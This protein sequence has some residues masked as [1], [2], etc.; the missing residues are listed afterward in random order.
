M[1]PIRL[2]FTTL[3]ILGV[4]LEVAFAAIWRLG[5]VKAHVIPF[6]TWI[7]AAA[8]L[9]LIGVWL[10]T[11]SGEENRRELRLIVLFAILF[12]LTMLLLY[13]SLSDD[14]HRYRW[15]GRIQVAGFNPYQYPPRSDVFDPLHDAAYRSVNGKDIASVYPPLAERTFRWNYELVS[16]IRAEKLLYAAFDLLTIWLLCALLRQRGLPRTRVLIYAWA[17]LSVVE[18][19]GSGHMDVIAIFLML[20]AFY[21][22]GRSDR[23]S[24]LALLGAIGVKFFPVV[25]LPTWWQN[26]RKRPW[27][28]SAALT[29]LFCLPY[30][31]IDKHFAGPWLLHNLREF[32]NRWYH[33][34][35]SLFAL[36]THMFGGGYQALEP[37]RQVVIIAVMAAIGWCAARRME[38]LRAA[39]VIL[40]TVLVFSPNVFPWYVLW[41]LPLLAFYPE[42]AWLYFSTGVFLA[43]QVLIPYQILGQWF[44]PSR[45]L[46]WL[47]YA[48]LF[49]L[50]LGTLLWRRWRPGRGGESGDGAAGN[51]WQHRLD[52]AHLHAAQGQEVSR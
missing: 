8:P 5:N 12:R 49:A 2:R 45:L 33:N 41:I 29:L 6:L 27:A 36:L 7:F 39:L 34:N 31:W 52:H 43:Y 14:A 15:E 32:S 11:R 4:L 46:Q 26:S 24:G 44:Y 42:P 30:L 23:L 37:A 16:S 51:G 35:D 50:L 22:L 18:I 20:A 47:E 19:A 3:L 10:V 25:L 9:Y 48:P 38:P 28:W 21:W 13:P 17:P 1:I 40:G